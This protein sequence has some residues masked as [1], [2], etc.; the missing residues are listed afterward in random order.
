[1]FG[2]AVLLVMLA[3]LLFS[4][5]V[6][7]RSVRYAID[8]GKSAKRWGWGA[9]IVIFLIPFWDWLPT[10]AIHQYFCATEAGFWT[11]KTPE[12]WK[13]ENPGVME[14]LAMSHLPSDAYCDK[15][16]KSV[17]WNSDDNTY[18]LPDGTMVKSFYDVN[19]RLMFV[20]FQ[21]PDGSSGYRLNERI[22]EVIKVGE[23]S[24]L[25]RWRREKS[26]IDS[27]TGEVLARYI[28]FSTAQ[29]VYGGGW[30]GWKFWLQS[31]HCMGGER[32]ASL[33]RQFEAHFRGVEK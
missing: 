25:N 33:M 19:K 18:H 2:L 26:V 11:Y 15:T 17:C 5:L 20:T 27:R 21:K 13:R 12:Q 31:N 7:R 29:G 24:F 32:N 3:Y 10:V 23:R 16:G 9:A 30:Y 22:D 8:R 4:I 6:V 28:D 14:T 1:M